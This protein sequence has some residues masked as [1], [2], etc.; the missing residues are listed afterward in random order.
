MGGAGD[1]GD[2]PTLMIVCLNVV[3]MEGTEDCKT[4]CVVNGVDAGGVSRD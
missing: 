1:T 3:F 4:S 2:D